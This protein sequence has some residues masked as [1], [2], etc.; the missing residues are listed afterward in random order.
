MIRAIAHEPPSH[1][2]RSRRS[3]TIERGIERLREA[4]YAVDS[5]QPIDMFPHTYHVETL[6]RLRLA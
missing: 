1:H 2:A 5:N 4:G 6:V 3:T